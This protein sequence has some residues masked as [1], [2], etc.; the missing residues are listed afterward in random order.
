MCKQQLIGEHACNYSWHAAYRS[1]S[2]YCTAHCDACNA[3]RNREI[4]AAIPLPAAGPG[5]PSDAGRRAALPARFSRNAGGA[6]REGRG[7]RRVRRSNR[8]R[9]VRFRSSRA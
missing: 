3:M 9:R 5:G 1:W 2:A 7:G 6:D 4:Q 8:G